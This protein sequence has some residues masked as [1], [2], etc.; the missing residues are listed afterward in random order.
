MDDRDKI[1]YLLELAG[2]HASEG[3]L[4]AATHAW[5]QVLELDPG[6][7]QATQALAQAQGGAGGAAPAAAAAGDDADATLFFEGGGDPVPQAAASGSGDDADATMMFGG[8]PAPAGGGG[9]DADATMMFSPDAAGDPLGGA[10]LPSAAP[11]G[12]DDADATMMFD[13][14]GGG[15]PMPAPA[16]TGGEGDAD[17]TM[18]FSP[19]AGD[20][21]LPSAEPPALDFGLPSATAE[22]AAPAPPAPAPPAEPAPD[23]G[24]GFDFGL[25]AA[26]AA[27]PAPPAPE[28]PAVEGGSLG[29]LDFGLGAAA[30]PPPPPAA[31]ADDPPPPPPPPAAAPPPPAAPEPGGSDLEDF[32]M[33]D[34]DLG[35]PGSAA[36]LTGGGG[37]STGTGFSFDLPPALPPAGEPEE[38]DAGGGGEGFDL[39]ALPSVGASGPAPP[40]PPPP[41]L[42][43]PPP[44]PPP[45]PAA[46]EPSSSGQ[47]GE[48][49]PG[50]IEDLEVP[51]VAPAQ[52]TG[53][54]AE[55]S[56]SDEEL[57][58]E[59]QE[60]YGQE[61]GGGGA[62]EPSPMYDA[63]L[64]GPPSKPLP[65]VLI[66]TLFAIIGIVGAVVFFIISKVA[67]PPIAPEDDIK[68]PVKTE[69]VKS[70][71]EWLQDGQTA[72]AAVQ[73][74]MQE[75]NLEEAVKQMAIAR[76]AFTKGE[77][78]VPSELVQLGDTLEFEQGW[79]AQ[80]EAAILD[81]CLEE[82]G[83]SKT[84]FDELALAKPDDPRP[85]EYI[86]RMYFNLA[87]KQMQALKP[88]E[89]IYYFEEFR[90]IDQ[91]DE[92]VEELYDFAQQFQRGQKL[93][94]EYTKEVDSLVYRKAGCS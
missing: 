83:K 3:N 8:E 87:L 57:A 73:A 54:E 93:G 26:D 60:M 65:W 68:R 34:D 46:S 11:A 9:D 7:A 77:A 28:P 47:F 67:D 59:Y 16:P 79:K 58:A 33:P 48:V 22:P 19:D 69:V 29:D 80:L 66:G 20:P 42:A 38:D 74:A 44:P 61:G 21:G 1:A 53:E 51:A 40:P 70:A 52:E 78:E 39:P 85:S 6:N 23:A 10:A 76:E 81:F 17:A 5:Q 18:M 43:P 30:P 94:Y 36:E 63:P 90:K 92:L 4:S 62:A 14:G 41:S 71:S 49:D 25:P 27:P 84:S 24:G 35:S 31:P 45:P 75:N 37:D 55:P 82:Y 50:E 56:K 12:G 88:W 89:A 13:P 15:P 86:S 91:A 72:M 64:T 2:S 32:V